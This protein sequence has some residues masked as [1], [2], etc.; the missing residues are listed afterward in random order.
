MLSS[1]LPLNLTSIGTTTN[2]QAE[3]RAVIGAL[4]EAIRLG[5]KKVDL[6]LDSE[7]IVRQINGR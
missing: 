2:N 3:Y 7:L 1:L 6:R 5:A 4:Q